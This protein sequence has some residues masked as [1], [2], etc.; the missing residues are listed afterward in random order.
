MTGVEI[1]FIVSD[2]LAALELYE[3]VFPI[4]RIEVTALPKG[5]NEA[6]FLLFGVRFHMLDANAEYGMEAPGEG[7]V[8]PMWFNVMVPG[9]EETFAAAAAAGMTVVQP[10]TRIDEM[11]VSNA[12]LADPFGYTWML[13][14]LHEIVEFDDRVRILTEQMKEDAAE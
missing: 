4:E 13:H 12:I 6:V 1:D 7:G 8:G 3:G 10:V 9:I 2:C 11:G 14:E 5:Q